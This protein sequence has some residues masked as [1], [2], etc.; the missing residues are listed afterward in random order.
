MKV[1]KKEKR[2]KTVT[3]K[4]TSNQD[5]KLVELAEKLGMTKSSLV[6]ELIKIGYISHTRKKTF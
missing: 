1:Q 3:T 6:S 2:D 5:E 4:I